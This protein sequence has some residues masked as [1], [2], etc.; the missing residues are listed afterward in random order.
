MQQ[1]RVPGFQPTR[2]GFQFTNN[3]WPA[4]PDYRLSILG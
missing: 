4:G 3:D 2:N 1:V